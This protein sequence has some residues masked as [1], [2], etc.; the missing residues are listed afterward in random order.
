[1]YSTIRTSDI[2]YS[3]IKNIFS[4]WSIYNN[5]P[6]EK[7]MRELMHTLPLP[8]YPPIVLIGATNV[9]S[10][11]LDIFLFNTLS[12]VDKIDVLM[13]TTAIPLIFPPRMYNNSLYID[14]GIISNEIIHQATGFIDCVFYNIT[15]IAARVQHAR[16]NITGFVSYLSTVLNTVFN[17]FDSQ[18][19]QLT[20]CTY[21]KG[22]INACFPTDPDLEKYSVLDF[23]HGKELYLSGKKNHNCIKY[24]LC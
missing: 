22:Q 12:L 4:R 19:A 2:Y 20:T 14:G 13:S 6:L 8:K 1:M 24:D 23:N 21:P 11:E 16:N 18:L 7:T 9:Y 15:F 10:E 5:A 3:D 17:T